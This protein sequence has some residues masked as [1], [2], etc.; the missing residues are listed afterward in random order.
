MGAR[1]LSDASTSVEG[2]VISVIRQGGGD[3]AATVPGAVMSVLHQHARADVKGS[4]RAGA[5]VGSPLVRSF[6]LMSLSRE[7]FP[8]SARNSSQISFPIRTS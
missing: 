6:V 1:A 7:A 3:A 4:A 2:N 8:P 5:R